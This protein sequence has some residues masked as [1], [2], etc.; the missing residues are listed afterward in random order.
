MEKNNKWC[1]D[2]LKW[3]LFWEKNCK[4]TIIVRRT[5]YISKRDRKI[6]LSVF[7]KYW[8]IFLYHKCKVEYIKLEVVKVILIRFK[9]EKKVINIVWKM[10]WVNIFAN[11]SLIIGWREYIFFEWI[12]EI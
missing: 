1:V 8:C 10:K 12:K 3:Q 2:I 4:E 5:E 11:D 9:I 6:V 7:V